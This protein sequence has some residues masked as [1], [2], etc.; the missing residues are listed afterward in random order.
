[1]YAKLCTCTYDD[2]NLHKLSY[3]QKKRKLSK[4]KHCEHAL[5]I[6]IRHVQ[7]YTEA[8][9]VWEFHFIGQKY[10]FNIWLKGPVF[11]MHL[12][13]CYVFSIQCIHVFMWNGRRNVHINMGHENVIHLHFDPFFGL[14]N[15]DQSNMIKI[16]FWFCYFDIS[17][18]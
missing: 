17:L 9:L 11:V 8:L 5:S 18:S 15:S 4:L 1:M 14:K 7:V 6:E 13:L 10:F 3:Y 2:H 12:T 16:S